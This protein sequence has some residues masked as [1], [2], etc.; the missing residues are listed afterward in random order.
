MDVNQYIQQVNLLEKKLENLE[1]G[2][3]PDYDKFVEENIACEQEVAKRIL[4]HKQPEVN[5]LQASL[6]IGDCGTASFLPQNVYEFAGFTGSVP[7]LREKLKDQLDGV[8][9]TASN[10]VQ[11]FIEE[12]KKIVKQFVKAIRDFFRYIKKILKGTIEAL[13]AIGSAIVAITGII[14]SPLWNIPDAILRVL[15]VIKDLEQHK[16]DFK[17]LIIFLTGLS[18]LVFVVKKEKIGPIISAI[19]AGIQIILKLLSPLQTIISFIFS[20]L[21]WFLKRKPSCEKQRRKVIR[22]IRRLQRK[23]N[24]FYG[25]ATRKGRRWGYPDGSWRDEL[26]ESDTEH[27]TLGGDLTY[28]IARKIVRNDRDLT[29]DEDAE[30]FIDAVE[31]YDDTNEEIK[32]LEEQLSNIC[33]PNTSFSTST[34]EE[35]LSDQFV[36]DSGNTGAGD[37]DYLSDAENLANGYDEEL[38]D[39]LI[40]KL[41]NDDLGNLGQDVQNI[42]NEFTTYAVKYPDGTIQK[43]VTEE[44][45]D[46]LKNI[47]KVEIRNSFTD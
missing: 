12:G 46:E 42:V 25:R 40:E 3:L 31:G 28:K 10:M 37:G 20:L 17:S 36:S 5:K 15:Q 38:I 44:E 26:F 21:S 13:I 29:T 14:I 19:G 2:L 34:E 32:N 18:L 11:Q 23:R 6:M 47:F 16:E 35:L 9:G 4:I 43:G 39:S 7:Q 30:R 1:V 33:K 41:I 24:R 8:W 22:R 45:L 27:I